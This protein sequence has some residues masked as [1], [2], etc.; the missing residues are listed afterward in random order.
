M[1]FNKN[2]FLAS[3]F[4]FTLYA[5]AQSPWPAVTRET[6]P[7][8]RWWW[9]GS[10]VDETGVN[11]QL[12]EL[13]NVGFGGVQVVPIYGA[14]GFED[15]YIDYLSPRWMQMLDFTVADAA[16][17]DMGVDISVGT[18]WPIGGPQVTTDDAASKLIMQT[19]TLKAGEKLKE[20]III[21]DA[22]QEGISGVFLSVVT[23]YDENGKA[24]VISYKVLADGTLQWSPKNGTWQVFALFTGKTGQKVKRAAK[25][26][27]GF[28][29]DHFSSEALG[30]YFKK[31]DSVFGASNHG[32]RS[33]FNDSYEV[34]GANWTADFFSEFQKR[35]GYDLKPYIKYLVTP[36]KD[37]LTARIKADYRETMSAL[38][39]ENFTKKFT[40]WAHEKKSI[41]TNQAHGSPANLL[42]LYAAVDVP[43]S[44]TFGSTPFYIPGLRSANEDN[45]SV[46]PDPSILKFASSAAHVSGKK[47]TSNETFT[48]LTEHFK[49]SWSQCKPEVEQVFLSGINH[50]FYHGTT[51]SPADL[52]FPGWLFY[53]SINVT[54]QNSLWPHLKGLNEYITRCQSI[55]QAGQPDNDILAYWPVYDSWTNAKGLDMPFGIHQIDNWLCPTDF[56]QNVSSLHSMGYDMDYTSDK[57]LSEATVTNG[58][59]KVAP[60]GAAYKVL[61]VSK[62]KYMPVA[63]LKSIIRLANEGGVVVMQQFPEDVPGLSNLDANRNELKSVIA[64]VKVSPKENGISEA[65][66]GKGKIIICKDLEKALIYANVKR[67]VLVDKGLKYIRRNDGNSKYYYIVNHT[68]NMV[69]GAVELNA[70]GESALLMDPQTGVTGLAE[71]AKSA[72]GTNVNL[73]IAPGEAMIVKISGDK[74]LN[75]EKWVYRTDTQNALVINGNWKLHFTN[76][77]PVVPADKNMKVL[78]PWTDFTDDVATQSFS[79]SGSYSTEF[80]FKP[81]KKQNYVLELDKLYESAAVKINGQDAGI[82]W[83]VPYKLDI[84]KFLKKG[85]NT[86]EIEVCNLMANHIRYM[87]SNKIEWRKYHEINFVNLKYEAFDASNWQVQP[88]GLGGEARI[89]SIR[90]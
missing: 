40:E 13:N 57:M 53:A 81:N 34:Y 21:N 39:L 20:K 56:Y 51:Y 73:Q 42:D 31:F 60:Q 2:I 1:I 86:I 67:E 90:K 52:A 44:E 27:E 61:A 72:N 54:P 4:C 80:T 76:G 33:F 68:E 24:E 50:V 8:T 30:N 25:G 66:I 62:T 83:S 9:M 45:E 17:K 88:S 74:L 79:G 6:K 37:E 85:K 78:T 43:E 28:T 23:A 64:S 10:A 58:Y 29:L 87:D 65:I 46:G 22:K 7:W 89:I 75:Q 5:G 55:L 70:T 19:Y 12:Q 49:T 59:I 35:R 77:G 48:W 32:V 18:G 36:A 15:K 26:G 14:K 11:A 63:T 41:N 71:V 3:A 69:E 82:I 84:T 38:M 16:K 47:L